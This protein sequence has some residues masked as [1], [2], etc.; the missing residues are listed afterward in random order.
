MSYHRDLFLYQWRNSRRAHSRTIQIIEIQCNMQK[1]F[2]NLQAQLQ[3]NFKEFGEFP[4]PKK[5]MEAMKIDN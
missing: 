1:T 5:Q 2:E 3:H 4:L